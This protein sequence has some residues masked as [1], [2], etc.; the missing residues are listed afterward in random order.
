VVAGSLAANWLPL[1]P[2]QTIRSG[3][4]AQVFSALE[5]VEV[6]TGLTLAVFALLRTGHEWA[7]D[8]EAAR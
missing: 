3:G 7:P 6:A 4:T 8:Q 2:P 1:A 5:M